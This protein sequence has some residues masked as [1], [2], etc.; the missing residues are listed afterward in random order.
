MDTTPSAKKRRQTV[1]LLPNSGEASVAGWRLAAML[2]KPALTIWA[3][4]RCRHNCAAEDT[5]GSSRVSKF[6]LERFHGAP[7][8]REDLLGYQ[9][10][11]QSSR[12]FGFRRFGPIA[13]DNC[14]DPSLSMTRPVWWTIS[15][16]RCEFRKACSKWF[17]IFRLFCHA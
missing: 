4:R 14:T 6:H 8:A 1:E 15:L 17:W 10:R 13:A 12:W 9:R 3:D 2:R 16:E 11:L 7:S 5:I